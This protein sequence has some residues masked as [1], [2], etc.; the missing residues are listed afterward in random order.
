MMGMH[1]A[2]ATGR[3]RGAVADVYI[4]GLVRDAGGRNTKSGQCWLDR[5]T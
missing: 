3:R 2:C 4:H 5:S 1:F